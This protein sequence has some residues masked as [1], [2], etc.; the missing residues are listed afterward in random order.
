MFGELRAGR[1]AN[2]V[3]LDRRSLA[4]RAATS[5]APELLPD[6]AGSW[7]SI[8]RPWHM[9]GKPTRVCCPTGP[10]PVRSARRREGAAW[11]RDAALKAEMLLTEVELR[12][13]PEAPPEAH[14]SQP[15]PE[16]RD[17]PSHP[18]PGAGSPRDADAPYAGRRR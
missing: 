5:V 4:A 9:G 18:W 12:P 17:E 15:A 8:T 14:Q 10:L 1:W 13:R 6:L 16:A 3:G 11:L 2:L 7:P